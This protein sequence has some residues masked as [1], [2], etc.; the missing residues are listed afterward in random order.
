VHVVPAGP[1]HHVPFAALWDGDRYL[2]ERA[3][4]TSTPTAS[5]LARV[6][7][8]DETPGADCVVFGASDLQAPAI[9][10]EVEHA[11][12]ALRTS[13]LADSAAT[14]D[15][16]VEV[17]A[18]AG[19]IHLACHGRFVPSSPFAS[20]LRFADRWFT[21]R[22]VYALRLAGPVVVL[23]GCDTGDC[24][25]DAGEELCGLVHAFFA[26]T[27]RSTRSAI[28]IS[29]IASVSRRRRRPRSARA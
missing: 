29:S 28:S 9:A 12:R 20:G 15:R 27:W 4:V 23:S 26:A 21:L 8:R 22:D 11:A 10:A 16:F 25:T 17:S 18:A 24:A 5:V 6:A 3:L 14:A 1:L 13:A 7:D 19:V 2:L